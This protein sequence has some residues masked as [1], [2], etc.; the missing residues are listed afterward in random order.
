MTG[1]TPSHPRSLYSLSSA[2]DFFPVTHISFQYYHFPP[3][4]RRL[5]SRCI[6]CQSLKASEGVALFLPCP[7]GSRPQEQNPNCPKQNCLAFT[8]FSSLSGLGFQNHSGAG[9]EDARAKFFIELLLPLPLFVA[10]NVESAT[11]I[12]SI[13]QRDYR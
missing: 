13:G 1:V 3:S 8:V 10:S 9:E 11:A 2:S 12:Y 4:P 7:P 5:A 6:L